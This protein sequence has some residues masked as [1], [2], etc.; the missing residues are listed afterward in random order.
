M[1]KFSLTLIA[2]LLALTVIQLW[3]TSGRTDQKKEMDLAS[4]PGQAQIGGDFTLTD[5]SGKIVHA[6][7]F[8]GKVML[9]FF[10][11]TQCPDICPVTVATL[12]KT[13]S[14][15]GDKADQVAPLFISVDPLHDTPAILKDFLSNFDH[16]MV[17]LTG[18]PEQ[19]EQVAEAYK[20]YYSKPDVPADAKPD[21]N[22][23]EY[24]IDHSA[25]IYMMGKD[26]KYV[27]IFPYNATEQEMTQAVEHYL[28]NAK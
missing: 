28:N 2:A 6:A 17:G 4:T 12:S 22:K 23:G 18:T 26:G 19:I 21:D 8:K 24:A 1:K 9:V 15:L 5:Q 3:L 14:L 13:M 16:R 20:V 11:F 25:F 10:G 7:D 27:R